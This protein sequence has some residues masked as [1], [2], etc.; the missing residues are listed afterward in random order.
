MNILVCVK[1][2]PVAAEV[3]VDGQFRLQ[4][5]GAKLQWN[6]ADE[7][8]LEAA[9]RLRE[10]TGTVTVLTMG[11]KKLEAP[12]QELFARGADR[13]VLLTDP[14]M[15]G[16]DTLATANALAAA[17]KHLGPFDLILCGRRTLDGET[18]Q[19]PGMVADKLELPCVTNAESLSLEN[20][21]LI[22]QRRLESGTARLQL[23]LPAV[24]SVCEYTYPLRLPGILAMRR[25]RQKQVE[26]LDA[27]ALQ[28]TPEVCGLKGSATRVVAMC[29][30]FPGLRKGPREQDAAIGAAQL[31]RM[32]REVGQ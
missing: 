29:A 28:L 18:G 12:L 9:L 32:C 20:H 27:A 23:C 2:V 4:R 5:D 8:A 16:A 15:A 21:V 10:Q 30:K 17:A 1:A 6:L 26:H 25:A 24:V 11:P 13:A 22:I 14:Q 19:V 31:V 7:A 3:Q